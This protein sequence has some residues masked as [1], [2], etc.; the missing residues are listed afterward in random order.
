MPLKLSAS[1]AVKLVIYFD[2]HCS[3]S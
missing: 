1:T 2:N 3:Y